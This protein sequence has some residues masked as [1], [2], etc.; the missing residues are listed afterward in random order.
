MQN[1]MFGSAKINTEESEILCLCKLISARKRRR[2]A[3]PKF[4]AMAMQIASLNETSIMES[5]LH[6]TNV[7]E[8]V[9]FA[10]HQRDRRTRQ[11]R[12]LTDCSDRLPLCL[13]IFQLRISHEAQ[14]HHGTGMKAV[15]RR[16]KLF[17]QLLRFHRFLQ[18]LNT[19]FPSALS[20]LSSHQSFSN[21]QKLLLHDTSS[22]VCLR[23]TLDVAIF[24]HKT[25]PNAKC[26][27]KFTNLCFRCSFVSTFEM[28]NF[29]AIFLVLGK[30]KKAKS[31]N[32]RLWGC[33]DMSHGNCCVWIFTEHF[34][35]M[36]TLGQ[37]SVLS[38]CKTL[39]LPLFIICYYLLFNTIQSV[40]KAK[41]S[42][43]KKT[44]NFPK[45]SILLEAS[46]MKIHFFFRLPF[47]RLKE[48]WKWP[49][50]IFINTLSYH[51]TLFNFPLDAS[52]QSNTKVVQFVVLMIT[53]VRC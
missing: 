42:D 13:I 6:P 51:S 1:V 45:L 43:W 10:I 25:S 14:I 20:A 7:R 34:H 53:S 48:E 29:V 44:K 49:P 31:S 39:L 40:R 38:R 30:K 21:L 22:V 37:S 2:L 11:K 35:R 50:R 16:T 28:E 26:I 12:I 23:L 17:V 24:H 9:N 15:T 4:V 3:I 33:E 18:H 27:H 47:E 46:K 52:N 8:S 41:A 32:N 19:N 36:F 5:I